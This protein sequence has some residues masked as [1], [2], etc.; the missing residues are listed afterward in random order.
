VL[1]R[2]QTVKKAETRAR[3]I[4]EFVEMLE[5]GER[6]HEPRSKHRKSK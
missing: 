3:K 6:I 1:F 5:R 4:R 2:I